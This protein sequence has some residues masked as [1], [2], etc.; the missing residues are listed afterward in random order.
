MRRLSC[1]LIALALWGAWAGPAWG[2]EPPQCVIGEDGI[3]RCRRPADEGPQVVAVVGVGVLVGVA[4]TVLWATRPAR[5]RQGAKLRRAAMEP[6]PVDAWL[7]GEGG[8]LSF[9]WLW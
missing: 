7:S 6:A 3:K 9:Q 1:V 2:S 4:F 8:G 5:S